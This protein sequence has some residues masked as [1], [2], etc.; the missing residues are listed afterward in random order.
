MEPSLYSMDLL[1]SHY[2][3]WFH[4]YIEWFHYYIAWFHYYIAC[5]RFY[6]W[7]VTWIHYIGTI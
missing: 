2:I 1:Q 7:S 5:L 6:I 3:A 4:Y